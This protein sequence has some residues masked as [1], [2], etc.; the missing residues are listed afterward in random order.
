[1]V[2]GLSGNYMYT[3]WLIDELVVDEIGLDKVRDETRR[4]LDQL[5]FHRLTPLSLH[6]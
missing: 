4:A 1:M 3:K 2:D 5:A 6:I